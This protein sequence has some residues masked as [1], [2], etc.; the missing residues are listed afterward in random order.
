MINCIKKINTTMLLAL[1]GLLGSQSAS[2][3]SEGTMGVTITIPEIIILH[4]YSDVALD[5]GSIGVKDSV[6]EG[7]TSISSSGALNGTD[8]IATAD[9]AILADGG[10][11]YDTTV[12]VKMQNAWAVRGL[13]STGKILVTPTFGAASANG[14]NGG[15]LTASSLTNPT[16]AVDAAGPGLAGLKYGDLEFVLDLADLQYSGEYTGLQIVLTAAAN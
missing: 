6:D 4:Y 11:D 5:L 12:T 13:T 14:N 16:G 1:V 15:T 3:A 8:S 9:V 2:A 10:T 7:A